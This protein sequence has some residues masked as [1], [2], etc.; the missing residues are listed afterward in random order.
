MSGWFRN[1]S[2]KARRRFVFGTL[3]TVGFITVALVAYSLGSGRGATK[4]AGTA[5][6]TSTVVSGPT[7]KLMQSLTPQVQSQL[8]TDVVSMRG[9]TPV[10]AATSTLHPAVDKMSKQQAD[11]YAAAFAEALLTQNYRTSRAGLLSWVQA[12]SATS[13]EPTFEE[14]TPVDLRNRLAVWS[15]QTTSGGPAVIPSPSDWST[16]GSQHGSQSAVIIKTTEPVSWATAVTAGQISDPAATTREVDATITDHT[17]VGG[18]AQ[19]K[20]YSVAL[21]MCLEARPTGYAFVA[22]AIYDVAEM[23]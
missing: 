16:F 6:G 3:S 2:V 14:L 4:M 23:S 15:V 12:E 8:G 5:P 18:V 20:S 13:Q 11:L 1:L 10:N 7:D 21:T 22:M 9:M 19:V 17:T